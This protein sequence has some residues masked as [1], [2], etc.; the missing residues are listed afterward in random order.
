MSKLES[1]VPPLELCKLIPAGEFEDSF[2][3]WVV[4]WSNA[5][6]NGEMINSITG[7]IPNGAII[8]LPQH[9]TDEQMDLLAKRFPG[10]IVCK[11]YYPAPTLE[12]IMAAMPYCRV[13]KKTAN[14][15]VAV[16]E[17]ERVPSFSGATAA[18]KLWLKLKGIEDGK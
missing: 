5:E 9:P 10:A 15:Y 7:V 2:A 1:L 8:K 18:L 6:I 16:K 11:E 13:Y 17:Q 3:K 12:E 4:K 14:F